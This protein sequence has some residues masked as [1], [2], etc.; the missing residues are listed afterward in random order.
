[1]SDSQPHSDVAFL[2]DVRA[3]LADLDPTSLT[4]ADQVDLLRA[5]EEVKAAT[6]AC[7]ARVIEVAGEELD[8]VQVGLAMRTSPALA[9]QF[10]GVARALQE[11]PH[12][13]AALAAGETSEYRARLAVKETA[14]LTAH[15]WAAVDAELAAREGGIEALGDRAMECTARGAADRIDPAGACARRARAVKQRRVGLRPAPDG[16]TRLSAV[17]PLTDGVGVYAALKQAAD[18]ARATGS[19]EGR[20][21]GEVMADELVARVTGRAAGSPATVEVNLVMSD[22]ALLASGETTDPDDLQ[23]PAVAEGFGPVPADLARGIVRD[24][25]TVWLR[26][27]FSDPDT[28]QLVGMESRA[29]VFPAGLR[30][31]VVVR[32]QQC[33]TPWCDAPVRHIDHVTPAEAGGPTSAD[34]AQGLCEACNYAKQTHHLHQIVDSGGDVVITTVTGHTYVSRPPPPPGSRPPHPEPRSYAEDPSFAEGHARHV[35]LELAG[36][37]P[38]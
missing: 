13:Q 22:L 9:R 37:Q 34:N 19:A 36:R 26:R 18:T 11:M 25:D 5:A 27:L 7:Q 24:A 30:R 14:H 31:F 16:M 10:V 17:L 35:V 12:V 32:D 33:R 15:D 20:N 28:G 8:H 6:A 29:R 2:R 23:E 21:R 1:M 4:A 3:W 38:A